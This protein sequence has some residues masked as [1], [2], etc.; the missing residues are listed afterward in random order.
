M[1]ETDRLPPGA[2]WAQGPSC[3][4]L[5]YAGET[6]L[7][8]ADGIAL[9]QSSQWRLEETR[10]VHA[11]GGLW[12]YAFI[13]HGHQWLK[14]S[15]TDCMNRVD[16]GRD[17]RGDLAQVKQMWLSHVLEGLILSPTPANGSPRAC[18]VDSLTDG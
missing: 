10:P 7:T 14:L 1:T 18:C 2:R 6:R 4:I 12:T 15:R 3:P 13:W 16:T 5:L 8:A 11:G 17:S 9:L